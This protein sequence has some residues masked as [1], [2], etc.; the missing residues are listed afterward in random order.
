MFV[1]QSFKT[2]DRE[3][4][5]YRCIVHCTYIVH[6]ECNFGQDYTTRIYFDNE[7]FKSFKT[8]EVKIKI[9]LNF[10]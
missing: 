2:S 4:L 9:E 10:F 8:F 5:A 1:K 7:K 3:T 6:V